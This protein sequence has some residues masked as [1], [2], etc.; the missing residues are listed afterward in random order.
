M[1]RTDIISFRFAMFKPDLH[2]VRTYCIVSY[3]KV[4]SLLA[5]IDLQTEL[6]KNK[7]KILS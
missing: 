4:E 6:K 7:T 5:L 3:Y 2:I 1:I